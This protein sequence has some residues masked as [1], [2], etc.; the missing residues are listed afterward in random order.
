MKNCKKIFLYLY[1]YKNTHFKRESKEQETFALCLNSYKNSKLHCL[2]PC[3][4]REHN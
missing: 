4:N 2:Y 3:A 1:I